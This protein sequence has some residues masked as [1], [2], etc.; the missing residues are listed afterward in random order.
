MD[1][2]GDSDVFFSDDKKDEEGHVTHVF[3]GYLHAVAIYRRNYDV[4][5]ID[6]TYKTN[7]FGMPLV[8][9]IGT[10]GLNST[11]HLAQAFVQRERKSDSCGSLRNCVECL[12]N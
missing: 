7:R 3:V 12:G 4:I 6:A 8:N 9:I 10:T 5:L 1:T 2:I 11:I